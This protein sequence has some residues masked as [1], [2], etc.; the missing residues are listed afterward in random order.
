[1][2]KCGECSLCCKLL[3]MAE[4]ERQSARDAAD[5][6]FKVGLMD[7]RTMVNAIEVFDKPAGVRCPHQ[8]HGKGCAL[9]SRRPFGC[10]VWTCRWLVN[11][12]TADL[13]RPDRAGYVIDVVPDF[14]ETDDPNRP[15][16]PVIQVWCDPKRRDAINDPALQ[17]FVKRRAKEGYCTLVRFNSKEDVVFLYVEDGK[18]RRKDSAS[19]KGESPH[20]WE[21]RAAA[22]G[23]EFRI[24]L[25][26]G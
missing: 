5:A 14:V 18:V 20:T 26:E 12:D 11:D 8:R 6:M 19:M 13:S 3:P 9:Y 1:M 23:G 10:R 16:V 7:P 24:A 15:T 2:R 22:I 17:E 25:A 21:E 4:S